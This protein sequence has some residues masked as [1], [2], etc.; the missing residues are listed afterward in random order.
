[1]RLAT[2][3]DL[4]RIL[5]IERVSHPEPW[6]EQGFAEEVAK[7]TLWVLDDVTAYLVMWIVLDEAQIQNITTDPHRRRAG[8]GK[9]LLLQAIEYARERHCTRMTLE[10]RET[11]AAAI[12]LYE[13]HGF[14]RVG[15]RKRF[16]SNG[17]AAVLMDLPLMAMM[18]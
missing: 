5:S 12:A 16:Y 18:K 1:M 10:V 3:A 15:L 6:T 4:P 17:D 9:T 14:V 7:G 2:T 13:T 11:N 8:L